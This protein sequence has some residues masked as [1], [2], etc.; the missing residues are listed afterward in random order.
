LFTASDADTDSIVQYD[1]WDSGIAGGT[2]LLNGNP[3]LLGVDNFVSAAQLSQVT[4]RGGH[5]TET[6]WERATDGVAY[7]AW[8][9]LNATDTAPVVT[10]TN[11]TANVGHGTVAATSLFTAGDGDADS[12]VQYDFWD[13]G[14]AGGHWLLNGNA[15]PN[16]QDNFVAG[17]QLS[18]VTYRGGAGT[19]TIYERASDGIQFGA[20]VSINATG[21]DIAPVV[22]PTSTSIVVSHNR[23]VAASTLF[24]VYDQDGDGE[25]ADHGGHDQPRRR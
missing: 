2:W 13:S 9:S 16:G 15:L 7:S 14:Q 18:Q 12:I 3:L 6:I 10:P 22:A 5:G 8:G 4:Y 24:T 1:L 19:E 11:S 21:T 17:S 23:S 25:R 20:W